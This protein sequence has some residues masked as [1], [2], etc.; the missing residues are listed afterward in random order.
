MGEEKWIVTADNHEML[1]KK[2]TNTLKDIRK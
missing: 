1:E 2:N